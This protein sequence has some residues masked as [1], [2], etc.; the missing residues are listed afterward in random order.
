MHT[1]H[2]IITITHLWFKK[3]REQISNMKGTSCLIFIGNVQKKIKCNHCDSPQF[4]LV[5]QILANVSEIR[6]NKKFKS[7][8]GKNKLSLFRD[9]VTLHKEN[10]KG[11]G[12]KS[13]ELVTDFRIQ[14]C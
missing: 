10:P 14:V 1:N 6:R 2:L 8:E 5:L 12:E 4:K 11:L 7:S 3:M 9:S 13:L